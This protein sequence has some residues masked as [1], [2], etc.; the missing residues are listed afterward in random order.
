MKQYLILGNDKFKLEHAYYDIPDNEFI[1]LNL[2]FHPSEQPLN[3]VYDGEC[4]NL[5][6]T[7]DA[8]DLK[9]YDYKDSDIVEDCPHLFFLS[10]NNPKSLSLQIEDRKG[11]KWVIIKGEINVG[12]SELEIFSVECPVEFRKNLKDII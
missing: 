3:S 12:R 8:K 11:S 1:L 7:Y 2:K 5:T 10:H 9:N 4:P 6:I